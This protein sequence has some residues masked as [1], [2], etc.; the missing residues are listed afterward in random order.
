MSHKT[1]TTNSITNS[2]MKEHVAIL[3]FPP[4]KI[5]PG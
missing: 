3:D 4:S 2:T 1:A 5:K